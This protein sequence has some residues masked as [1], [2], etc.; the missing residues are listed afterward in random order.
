MKC[1]H[2]NL[3]QTKNEF[4]SSCLK[5]FE[6]ANNIIDQDNALT[7]EIITCP[8]CLKPLP[9]NINV[10]KK[11]NSSYDPI[12]RERNIKKFM[13][14]QA[15]QR[16]KL[17]NLQFDL[18]E[19]QIKIPMLC[20]VLNIPL[21]IS[22]IKQSNNSPSLDRIDNSKGYTKDNVA[23]ISWKAN[24]LKSNAQL[25]ELKA[26]VTYMESYLK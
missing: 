12:F 26:I 23:V 13:L 11:C 19:D 25:W 22:T 9:N 14:K 8:K 7:P 10:C 24:K 3:K 2:C 16:A 4:C 17:N 20:P 15:K 18:I 21:E 6:I 5:Q 1:K